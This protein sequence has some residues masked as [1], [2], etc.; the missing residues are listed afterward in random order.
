MIGTALFGQNSLD[1]A[2]NVVSDEEAIGFDFMA[3]IVLSLQDEVSRCCDFLQRI[4][5]GSLKI[6]KTAENS[7]EGIGSANSSCLD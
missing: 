3:G 1:E 4:Q 6:K 7:F 5:K 2:V